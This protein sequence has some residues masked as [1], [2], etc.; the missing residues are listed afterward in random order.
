MNSNN[1]LQVV[2]DGSECHNFTVES[3][4]DFLQILGAWTLLGPNKIEDAYYC[5]GTPDA[6]ITDI[7]GE[8]LYQIKNSPLKLFSAS[9]GPLVILVETDD[10]VKFS[11]GILIGAADSINATASQEALI[12]ERERGFRLSYTLTPC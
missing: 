1:A 11:D 7:Y 9:G 6:A 10:G 8:I 12:N 5:G 3:N 2:G 4:N